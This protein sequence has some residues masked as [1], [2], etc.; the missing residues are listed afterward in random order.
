MARRRD[1]ARGLNT[2]RGRAAASEFSAGGLV[3]RRR[4]GNCTV[5]LAARRHPESG[6]LFWMLPKGHVEPGE[7]P[8]DAARREVREETGLDAAVERPLGDVTYWYL[9]RADRAR[10]RR[11]LK[12]VRF[13]LVRF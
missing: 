7:T 4:A 10:P 13:F 12:S 9:R 8:A 5:V 1:R 2:R 11:L 3:Y 6:A